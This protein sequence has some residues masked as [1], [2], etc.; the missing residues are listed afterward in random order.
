MNRW[1]IVRAFLTGPLVEVAVPKPGN[2]NRFKDF[3]DLSIYNFIVSYPALV[4]IYHE[5]VKRGE[6]IRSGLSSPAEAGIGELIRRAVET[7]RRVQDANPNF[8]V[9]VLSIPLMMGLAMTK[10]LWEGGEKT[11]IL[12]AESTVGDTMELYRAIRTAEPKGLPRGVKYDVYS[13]NS[14]NELFRDRVNLERLAELS[15]EREMVFCEWRNGYAL[16]YRTFKRILEHGEGMPLEEAVTRAFL[17]LLVEEGD[18]L[19]RRKGG[20]DEELLVKER[21]E[22]VLQGKSSLEEFDEFLREKGDLRNPG[23]AADITA[24]ALSLVFLTGVGVKM[25]EGRAWLTARP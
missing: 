9:I 19:I 2:V 14:F 4:G 3:D 6:S 24:T 25:R 10:K 18:S 21:A 1:E 17:E 23:S 5:A 16:T 11:K 12:I 7:T 20:R 13:E 8:G 15:C 22:E